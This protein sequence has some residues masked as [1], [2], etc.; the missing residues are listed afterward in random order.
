MAQRDQT[1][2]WMKSW[3]GRILY[4]ICSSFV[5]TGAESVV[6]RCLATAIMV[7]VLFEMARDGIRYFR[8]WRQ[9]RDH[10]NQIQG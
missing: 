4:L 1:R 6:A 2:S 9:R 3:P 7:L 8:A 5:A 10:S